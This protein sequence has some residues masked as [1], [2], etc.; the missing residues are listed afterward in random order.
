MFVGDVLT[1]NLYNF[2]LNAQRNGL[3]LS[4]APES[5]ITNSQGQSAQGGI[6]LGK[7]FGL[8][9]DI[10]VSPDGYLYILGYGGTVY[11]VIPASLNSP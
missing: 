1:G 5:G 6:V 7:G 9:T 3:I 11:K 10:Q 4:G 2:K 8:I